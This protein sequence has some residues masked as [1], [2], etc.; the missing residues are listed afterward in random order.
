[1]KVI[2]FIL[3]AIGIYILSEI[4]FP[5]A[6]VPAAHALRK[7]ASN[8]INQVD[9]AV[10]SIAQIIMPL[11]DLD[12]IKRTKLTDELKN[13]GYI[14]TP[15]MF[16]AK[17]LARGLFMSLA[18][19]L[20]ALVSPLIGVVCMAIVFWS[21]YSAQEKRLQRELDNRKTMIERELPQFAGTI[22]QSLNSTHDVIAI[23]ESYR[24]VCGV[25]LKNEIDRTLNDMKTGNPER[26]VKALE[27]RVNSAELSQLTRG[28]IGVLR[29]DDQ[30]IYFDM[31]TD[32]YRKAQDEAVKKELIKRPEKL[33][34]NMGMLFGCIFLMVAVALGLYL[35]QQLGIYF[36]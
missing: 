35:K 32:E 4:K 22:R 20:V 31:L 6:Y 8:K 17:A 3:T 12:P 33:L 11:I 28:L 21:V 30:R 36:T 9:V 27:S 19:V 2:V 24:K 18:F 16:H 29:G 26:A 25:S 13:L 14:E 1:M 23:F 34:P 10:T 7:R 15:E 5:R